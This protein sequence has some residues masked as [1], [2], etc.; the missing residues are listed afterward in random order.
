M[1]LAIGIISYL[2]NDLDLRKQRLKMH[3]EQLVWLE[4]VVP[5]TVVMTAYQNYEESEYNECGMLLRNHTMFTLRYDQGVG[6]AEAR[7]RILAEFYHSNWDHLLLLDDDAMV[8]P[9]YQVEDIFSEIAN[10][11]EKFKGIDAF[12]AQHPR[13]LPFKDRVYSDKSNLT[14]WKFTRRPA[15]TGAQVA[16]LSNIRKTKNLRVFH[17]KGIMDALKEGESDFDKICSEDVSFHL[18]WLRKGLN[19]FTLETMQLKE[20]PAFSTIFSSDTRERVSQEKKLIENFVNLSSDIG[21]KIKDGKVNW[22]KVF[23]YFDTTP[24]E[25]RVPRDIPMDNFPEN[26]TPK[27]VQ[28][29]IDKKKKL[30]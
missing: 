13:Y 27:G 30:F 8:Y 16:I 23:G 4:R 15:N 3:Q 24:K 11:P 5:P 25:Y 9:Y 22:K 19:Y 2:P 20:S 12:C 10:N 1:S 18:D 26:V 17:Q 7:N 28:Q 14:N 29:F 6:P 21:L